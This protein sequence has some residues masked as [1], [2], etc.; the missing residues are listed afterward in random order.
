M[1]SGWRIAN[2]IDEGAPADTPDVVDDDEQI[3]RVDLV[4]LEQRD[5]RC[6]AQVHEG[7]RLGQ[8]GIGRPPPRDQRLDPTR[9]RLPLRVVP[10]GQQIEDLEA[11]SFTLAWKE[12]TFISK[13]SVLSALPLALDR[14]PEPTTIAELHAR[15][16]QLDTAN[17]PPRHTTPRHAQTPAADSVTVGPG[18]GFGGPGGGVGCQP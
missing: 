17:A 13:D 5:D 15:N 7:E 14:P 3:D 16:S 18:G 2:C 4:E 1:R 11:A 6:P 12:N 8:D 9:P 10:A